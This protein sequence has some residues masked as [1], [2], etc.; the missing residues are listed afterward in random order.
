MTTTTARFGVGRRESHDASAFY[1]RRL[2][3]RPNGP[4]EDVPAM[5]AALALNSSRAGAGAANLYPDWAVDALFQHS[6]ECMFEL[7][8]GCVALAVTSPPYSC[9]KQYDTDQTLVE[10]LRLLHRVFRET[11]RVLVPGG[12]AAINVAGLGRK[13][14][15]PLQACVTWLLADAGLMPQGEIIWVKAKGASGSCAWGT[16]RSARNPVLRDAHEYVVIARK[17]GKRAKG[18]DTISKAAFQRGTIAKWYIPAESAKRV[19]HA[20]P[21]PVELPRRLIEL[22]AYRNELV[23]DPFIGSGSTALA[24]RALQRYFVGYDTDPASIALAQRRLAADG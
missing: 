16:F 9:G 18:V 13:P 11:A 22:Y 5:L 21:F 1:G 15:V 10:Y 7:P 12:H 3:E 4:A 14:Y 6:S 19:G 8:D 17:P 23:L 20:A 24:A 2:F